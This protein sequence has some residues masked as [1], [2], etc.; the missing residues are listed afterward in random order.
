MKVPSQP[1]RIAVCQMTSVDDVDQNLK[2]ILD[3][4]GEI[5]EPVDLVTFP[6]NSLFFRLQKGTETLAMTLDESCFECLQNEVETRGFDLLLGSA[7]M[8]N[9]IGRPGN[10]T[11]YF[12]PG[13]KPRVVY[14]KIHLFDVDVVGSP[15]VRE[16]DSFSHGEQPNII[17]IKSWRIGLSICY[18]V[19]FAELYSKYAQEGVH[20]ILV[21]SAFLV[22]TGAAHWHILLRARAI[23]NQAFVVAAAQAG[24]HIGIY[25]ER[26][27][28]YGHSLAIDPWGE[29]LM[30]LGE[31]GPKVQIVTLDPSR[32]EKVW[33]QIPQAGHRRLR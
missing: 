23:E 4:L 22:P 18:D 1:L 7:P 11:V 2:Q 14:K 12:T 6:E 20:L 24:E 26:R 5:K 33:R 9:G 25:G 16:S 17:E 15:P 28:T 27:K 21:P 31:S 13:M 29:V 8:D 19:R 10:A 3:L 32:L 30:D